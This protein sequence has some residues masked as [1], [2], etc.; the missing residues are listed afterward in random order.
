MDAISKDDKT[1]YQFTN[2]IKETLSF[3]PYAE[4]LFIS[5]KTGQR[6]NKIYELIDAIIGKSKYENPYR[7][8]K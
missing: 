8:V 2:K 4:I 3:I 1:I 7:S 6:L 5:A